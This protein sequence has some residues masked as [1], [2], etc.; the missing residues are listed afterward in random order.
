VGRHNA[1]VVLA[2]ATDQLFH[3]GG[4]DASASP[5]RGEPLNP[6]KPTSAPS[7]SKKVGASG[8]LRLATGGVEGSGQRFGKADPAGFDR[9]AEA[10]GED[11][12][13]LCQGLE[14]VNAG[15]HDG[16]HDDH[17]D[18]RNTTARARIRVGSIDA[19]PGLR[20]TSTGSGSC[21][22][23]TLTEPAVED[24]HRGVTGV[25]LGRG[26]QRG[27]LDWDVERGPA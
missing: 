17:A 21:C 9:D 26:D 6:P 1:H 20:P 5:P 8:I 23:R 12:V 16:D 25:L 10:A 7:S 3:H 27:Q 22:P 11:L 13:T 18:R 15:G 4:G 14:P 19:P 24:A 2:G